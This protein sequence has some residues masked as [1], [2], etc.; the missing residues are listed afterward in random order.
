MRPVRG[1]QTVSHK[2]RLAIF[3]LYK[4]NSAALVQGK[5]D[6]RVSLGVNTSLSGPLLSRFDIVLVL[7]DLQNPDWDATVA[8]HILFGATTPAGSSQDVVRS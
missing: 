7:Q 2:Q 3:Q 5:Y 4:I 6:S 1:K 8:D